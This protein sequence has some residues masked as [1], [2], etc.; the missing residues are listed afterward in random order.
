MRSSWASE[1]RWV[2]K[3][4]PSARITRF[5]RPLGSVSWIWSPGANG[6]RRCRVTPARVAVPR[7]AATWS[8]AREGVVQV[9]GREYPVHLAG[10]LDE[11]VFG[12]RRPPDGL[13]Q[14]HPGQIGGQ[15][16]AGIDAP[17]ERP[18]VDPRPSLRRGGHDRCLVD[19]RYR[20][21]LVVHDHQGARL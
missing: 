1:P 12:G 6:P 18:G 15:H 16:Q 9:T 4:R 5:L 21:V 7:S 14:R 10:G 3:V 17:G 8:G 20:L 2:W 11:Q 13:D 19:D